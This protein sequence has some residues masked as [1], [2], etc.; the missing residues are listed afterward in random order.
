MSTLVKWILLYGVPAVIDLIMLII[1]IKKDAKEY[2]DSRFDVMDALLLLFSLCPIANIIGLGIVIVLFIVF[3]LANLIRYMQDKTH[4]KQE[5][6][7]YTKEQEYKKLKKALIK[8]G[9]FKDESAIN[10]FATSVDVYNKLESND[11]DN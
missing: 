4:D 6:K 2:V 5:V 9:Y 11:N 3:G 8:A 10:D 7:T 1:S